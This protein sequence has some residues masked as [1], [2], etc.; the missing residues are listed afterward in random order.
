MTHNFK[1]K[2]FGA[3]RCGL[4]CVPHLIS[5][6]FQTIK[7]IHHFKTIFILFFITD[8]DRRNSNASVETNNSFQQKTVTVIEKPT[9]TIRQF[10]SP[11]S[12]RAF[13]P[14]SSSDIF[15][16]SSGSENIL[17]VIDKT[18]SDSSQIDQF[19]TP[20]TVDSI[21]RPICSECHN[22]DVE[23]NMEMNGVELQ[24]EPTEPYEADKAK[25]ES[26]K[27]IAAEKV[28]NVC[29]EVP[30]NCAQDENVWQVEDIKNYT[31]VKLNSPEPQPD[32]PITNTEID[33]TSF[34]VLRDDENISLKNAVI[35]ETLPNSRDRCIDCCFCNPDLHRREGASSAAS[36]NFCNKR[37]QSAKTRETE[38][39]STNTARMYESLSKSDHTHIKTKSK[40][41]DTVSLKCTRTN[42]RIRRFIPEDA[43]NGNVCEDTDEKPNKNQS[44]KLDLSKKPPKAPI[45]SPSKKVNIEST[46]PSHKQN[47]KTTSGIRLPSPFVTGISSQSYDSTSSHCSSSSCSPGSPK[48]CPVLPTGRWQNNGV[49]KQ[50]NKSR[51]SRYKEFYGENEKKQVANKNEL[52]TIDSPNQN[53]GK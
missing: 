46:S 6:C 2:Y 30:R 38:T 53:T 27:S 52:A 19:D 34:I 18:F 41:S 51:A 12:S 5:Q 35:D 4:N 25:N 39:K 29:E 47:A 21:N 43:L 16:S 28:E 11:Y 20:K 10:N 13:T 17:T 42:S 9:K 50:L 40:E 48:K 7:F 45:I 26:D 49:Q 36:C 44:S 37:R 22:I 14:I 31:S 23:L 15:V 33:T 3:P 24:L 8:D 32:V 1:F